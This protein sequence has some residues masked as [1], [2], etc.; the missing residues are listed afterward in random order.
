KKDLILVGG[1][2]CYP[3]EVEEVLF[4]HP[5]VA[6]A[7][8]IGIP[9]PHSGEEVKAYV[10]LREGV[11]ATEEEI[12]EFTKERLAG[13]KRPRSIEFRD[14]LPTSAVGKVLRR[15]LKDEQNG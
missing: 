15:V 11:E 1:F 9:S 2:N 13:Y 5:K 12:I 7:A 8:V 4:Q 14:A 6:Q 10:Q 3:R